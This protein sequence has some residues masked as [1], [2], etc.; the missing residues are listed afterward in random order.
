MSHKYKIKITVALLFWYPIRKQKDFY[1][2]IRRLSTNLMV[3]RVVNSLN[4]YKSVTRVLIICQTVLR[5]CARLAQVGRSPVGFKS[6]QQIDS[7]FQLARGCRL[8]FTVTSCSRDISKSIIDLSFLWI[9][10]IS[11][12]H[13]CLYNEQILCS[14]YMRQYSIAQ[15]RP[16]RLWQSKATD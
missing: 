14:I 1:S 2:L 12:S 13:G 9:D 10:L 11:L 3:R 15:R 8:W 16:L 6:I 4:Q 7:L 5:P